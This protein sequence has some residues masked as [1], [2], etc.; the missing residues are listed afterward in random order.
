M[1]KLK[2]IKKRNFLR[3]Q[4]NRNFKKKARFIRGLQ[5]IREKKIDI[6][7]GYSSISKNIKLRTE[8]QKKNSP[9]SKTF[10]YAFLF[11]TSKQSPF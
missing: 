11:R 7:N 8:N 6:G 10:F 3:P 1:Q 4:I 9:K 5:V 2:K